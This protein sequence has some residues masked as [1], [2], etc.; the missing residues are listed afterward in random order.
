M[1]PVRVWDKEMRPYGP[2]PLGV[3]SEEEVLVFGGN[4]QPTAA[5][6]LFMHINGH[7]RRN[8]SI[9]HMFLCKCSLRLAETYGSLDEN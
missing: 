1:E 2:V 6:M 9:D 8:S 7:S 5:N 3:F 4:R